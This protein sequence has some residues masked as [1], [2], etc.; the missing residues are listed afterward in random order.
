M[1]KFLQLL[2]LGAVLA[3]GV[4]ATASAAGGADPAIGTWTLNL[5][6][7]KYHDNRAPKSMTRTYTA[8]AGGTDMKVTGTAADGWPWLLRWLIK[9]GSSPNNSCGAMY[10]PG[11]SATSATGACAL[12]RGSNKVPGPRATKLCPRGPA[13]TILGLGALKIVTLSG[14]V[15]SYR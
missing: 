6:K 11:D 15:T 13:N 10:S 3:L 9:A 8:A 1:N 2:T 4:D 12:T 5:D 14:W 7:S